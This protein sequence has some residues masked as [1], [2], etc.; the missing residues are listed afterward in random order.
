MVVGLSGTHMVYEDMN[1]I[2]FSGINGE[3]RTETSLPFL[4]SSIVINGE[5]SKVSFIKFGL[6]IYDIH[7][8]SF[9][10]ISYNERQK[11]T[12]ARVP[13]QSDLEIGSV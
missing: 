10:N 5:G 6:E 13:Y 11:E 7:Q 12:K 2:F 9:Q 4:M 3:N 1:G 8:D